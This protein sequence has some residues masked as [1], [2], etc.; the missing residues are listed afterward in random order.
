MEQTVLRKLK[1]RLLPYLFLL[2]VI[3]YLD[4]VNVGFAALQM[5][6]DLGFND[7]VFGLGSGIFFVG[8]MLFQVPSN[9]V[10]QRWGA[11]RLIATLMVVWGCC[12]MAMVLVKTVPHFYV[13]R[14][15]LGLAEAGFFPGVVLYLTFWFPE[16]QRAQAVSLFMT[17]TA[18]SGVLG[19]PLSGAL[20]NMDGHQGVQGWQ[21]LFLIEAFPAIL[22]GVVTWFYLPDRPTSAR[23]LTPAESGWLVEELANERAGRPPRGSLREAFTPAV[24]HLCFLYF[25]LVCSMYSVTLWMPQII[26]GFQGFSDFAVGCLSAIPYGCAAY[27]MVAVGQHS[28]RTGERRWHVAVSAWV[29]AVG[30]VLAA[31]FAHQP[32]LGLMALALAALGIWG[33]VG[34]FWALPTT[35]LEG[36]AAAAGIALINSLGNLGGFVGPYA[37]GVIKVKTGHFAAGLYGLAGLLALGG[38]LALVRM[39]RK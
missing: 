11:R 13:L 16:R 26:K 7:E 39:G 4:R 10:L 22:L 1:T 17:A 34:P 29:G 6:Q 5:N 35:M 15:L 31:V 30:L 12:S 14:F 20:L 8:Y 38:V 2:Y 27:G 19:G 25:S 33:T 9:L 36:T 28:D 37:V 32:W 24:W 21:W 3:A 18:I 23:W